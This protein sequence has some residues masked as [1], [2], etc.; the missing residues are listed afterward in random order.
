MADFNKELALV[1]LESF[2]DYPVD[3]DDAWQWLG[4]AT[5]QKAQKKLEQNFEEGV[6]YTIEKTTKRIN[7]RNGGG[8]TRYNKIFIT[9]DCF[10]KMKTCKEKRKSSGYNEKR[11]QQILVKGIGGKI[12]VLTPAGKIDLLTAKDL[13]E[14]KEAKNWKSALGQVLA[15]GFYYPSHRKIVYLFGSYHISFKQMVQSIYDQNNV[16]L[17]W[18]EPD[19]YETEQ[20]ECL[21][22]S[23]TESQE[24]N[25]TLPSKGD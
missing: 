6:D 19:I 18:I 8:S 23:R 25:F 14:I 3:L 2:E 12:E 10:E 5:K 21:S 4:Y 1:L 17:V 15:Y 22:D 7:G 9:I 24:S 16:I 13:I 20:I 11:I